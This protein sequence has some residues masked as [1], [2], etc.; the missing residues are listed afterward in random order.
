MRLFAIKIKAKAFLKFNQNETEWERILCNG[1]LCAINN[2]FFGRADFLQTSPRK[3]K[4]I[5]FKDKI[6]LKDTSRT[7][8]I[9]F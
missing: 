3:K 4:T 9:I 8:E 5:L 2:V 6:S 1:F 7:Y